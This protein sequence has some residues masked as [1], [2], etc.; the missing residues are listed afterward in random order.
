MLQLIAKSILGRAGRSEPNAP[1]FFRFRGGIHPEQRKHTCDA[2]IEI[3]PPP[4]R[5]YIPL[6]QHAGSPSRALV[7]VGQHVLKGELIADAMDRVSAPVHASTSG[8]VVAISEHVAPHPSG[9]PCPVVVVESDGLDA[10]CETTPPADPLALT[11]LEVAQLIE[12]GGVVGLGGAAFPAAVKLRQAA[13]KVA[14]LII[15]AAE[16]EPYLT[17]DDRVMRERALGVVDGIRLILH[18]LEAP[19][20][21]IGIEDNKPEAAALLRHAARGHSNIRVAEVPTRF[22]TG[23][24]KQ[25]VQILTGKEVPAKGRSHDVG[26]ILH[27]VSTAYAVHRAVRRGRPLVSR[28]VTVAGDAVSTPKNLD[29]PIGTPVADALAACGGLRF[30]AARLVLGGP[31]TGLAI[32]D[33]R[34]PIVKGT[35]GVLALGPDEVSDQT[36]QPCIRCG[37]CIEACPMSLVPMEM[38]ASARANQLEAAVEFGLSDCIECGSCAFVCPSNIPL[39]NYFTYAKGELRAQAL[40]E[41]RSER[42]KA[43][44]SARRERLE[45]EK[46]EKAEAAKAAAAAR[47]AARAAKARP[48]LVPSEKP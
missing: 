42:L 12:R 2:E 26:V 40:D 4:E 11:P 15:N 46:R 20:A 32:H 41:R 39:V 18:A 35:T 43:R 7:R 25:L 9:L 38:S 5:L 29:I 24:G 36:E 31:M 37:R 48:T 47:K 16:C 1:R 44:A 8:V 6:L 22:P 13:G 30:P 27:N 3:L 21:V 45:R 14:T 28:V 33:M 34:A 23:S 17:C 19:E 10:W